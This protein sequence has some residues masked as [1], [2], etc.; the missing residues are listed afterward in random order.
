V[1]IHRVR[2]AQAEGEDEAGGGEHRSNDPDCAEAVGELWAPISS[3]L[4]TQG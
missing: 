2:V 4:K 3:G 1:V